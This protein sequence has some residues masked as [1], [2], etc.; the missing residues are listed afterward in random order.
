MHFCQIASSDTKRNLKFI[1]ALN[2][3]CVFELL[4]PNCNARAQRGMTSYFPTSTTKL[5]GKGTD[6]YNMINPYT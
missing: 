3:R 2:N 4:Q 5:Q 6:R 1:V